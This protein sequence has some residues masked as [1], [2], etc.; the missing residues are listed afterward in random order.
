MK[1]EKMKIGRFLQPLRTTG[2]IERTAD[3]CIV[4]QDHLKQ[5]TT[6]PQVKI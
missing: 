3:S 2:S 5:P 4:D 1:L 6:L